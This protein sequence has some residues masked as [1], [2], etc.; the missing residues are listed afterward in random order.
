MPAVSLMISALLHQKFSGPLSIVCQPK[1][2]R[3]GIWQSI[4]QCGDAAMWQC[5]K[6]RHALRRARSHSGCFC[7]G[8][9]RTAALPTLPH[10]RINK[11]PH[12]SYL[13]PAFPKEFLPNLSFTP[14]MALYR[15]A[16]FCLSENKFVC[17]ASLVSSANRTPISR[18]FSPGR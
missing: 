15:S 2:S 9:Q 7:A 13:L 14:S 3:E 12:C 4:R 16:F 18:T 8:R 5:R 17:T 6:A 11:L 1:P 10:Y